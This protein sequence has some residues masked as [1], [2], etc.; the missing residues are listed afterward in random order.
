MS[1]LI[2]L[3]MSFATHLVS[4]HLLTA[5]DVQMNAMR[6]ATEDNRTRI[7]QE[8]RNMKVRGDEIDRLKAVY[9][10]KL[11]TAQK[12]RYAGKLDPPK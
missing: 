8:L 7:T 9:E 1:Y 4:T 6:Q 5:T 10:E 3:V 11:K 12:A 2:S